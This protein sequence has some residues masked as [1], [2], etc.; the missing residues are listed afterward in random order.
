MTEHTFYS[1]QTNPDNRSV[2]VPSSEPNLVS[3]VQE[4][5]LSALRV[6]IA[7][8]HQIV[9]EGLQVMLQGAKGI[10]IVGVSSNSRESMQVLREKNVDV[11]VTD[12]NMPGLN[13]V[14]MIAEIRK[15]W[16]DL[17]IVVLTMYHDARLLKRLKTHNI[18]AYLLKNT[19]KQDL[20]ST[21]LKVA[22][23]QTFLPPD[24]GHTQSGDFEYS[25][26]DSENIQDS[27]VSKYALGKRELEIF[28]LIAQ[29]LSSQ[30]IAEQLFISIETVHSHRKNIKFKTNLKNTAE[31]TAFAVR[32]GLI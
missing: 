20:A 11:L 10:D 30:E 17:K 28:A 15:N 16:P 8:D 7:D 3:V 26:S 32:N 23:G 4:P 18:E 13:G 31:I 6:A 25:N 5:H 19:S 27:F 2:W 22:E 1:K 12:L 9:V 24:L 14:E 21:V 29:G